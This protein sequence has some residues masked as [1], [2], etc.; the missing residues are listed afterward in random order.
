MVSGSSTKCIF[1][2]KVDSSV[3]QGSI[4]FG[5]VQVSTLNQYKLISMTIF[6]FFYYLIEKMGY[7][8]G[9]PKGTCSTIRLRIEE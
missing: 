2:L 1:T 8:Y 4:G 9:W 6:M 5:A 3:P 7:D